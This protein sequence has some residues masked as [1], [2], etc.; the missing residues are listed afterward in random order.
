M[1]SSA[2]AF[3]DIFVD[4]M[5]QVKRFEIARFL[6]HVTDWEQREYFEMY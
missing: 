5:L 1:S 3:G 6:E 4:Y 2:R